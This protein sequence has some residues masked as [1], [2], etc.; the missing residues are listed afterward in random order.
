MRYK[1]QQ[2]IELTYRERDMRADRPL[3]STLESALQEPSIPVGIT[4]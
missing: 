2:L 4:C 1:Y 3:L